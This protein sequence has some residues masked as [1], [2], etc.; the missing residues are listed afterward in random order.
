MSG[1]SEFKLRALGAAAVAGLAFALT[2]TS[3]AQDAKAP[4]AA[5]PAETIAPPTD[6]V[7][8][9]KLVKSVDEM[10]ASA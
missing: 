1:F 3:L 6:P 9:A 10:V 2:G 7:Q 5:S 4:A 8:A